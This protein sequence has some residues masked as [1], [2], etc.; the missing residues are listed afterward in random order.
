MKNQTYIVVHLTG[1][2]GEIAIE[3]RDVE[4]IRKSINMFG[5][6]SLVIIDGDVIKGFDS[7]IDLSKL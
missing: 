4:W 3:R 2:D 7:K 6:Y 5:F 1:T